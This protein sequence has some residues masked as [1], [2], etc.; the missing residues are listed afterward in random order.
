MNIIP[1]IGKSD[2]CT[3]EELKTFKQKVIISEEAAEETNCSS[4]D[5]FC[6]LRIPLK[7][8][9]LLIADPESA[10]RI[11]DKCLRL[12]E[13]RERTTRGQVDTVCCSRQ[14]CGRSGREWKEGER[15]KVSLGNGQ[16]RG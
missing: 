5:V 2:A 4:G 8:Y 13:L 14:Q 3:K 16:H 11:P 15:K 7:Y 1:V 10:R 12:P 9:Y 6:G